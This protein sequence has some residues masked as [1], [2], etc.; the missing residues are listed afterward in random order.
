MCQNWS[1][2]LSQFT[3]IDKENEDFIANVR[4]M[5]TDLQQQTLTCVRVIISTNNLFLMKIK[6]LLWYIL[7]LRFGREKIST[8]IL[9]LPLIQEGQLSV[10]GE[11]MGT[12]YW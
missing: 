3:C 9:T 1:T 4:I 11:R 12:K 5:Y 6:A 2:E 10:T 7:S 8:T